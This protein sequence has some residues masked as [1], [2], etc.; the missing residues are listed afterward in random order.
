MGAV[1]VFYGGGPV[2]AI[3]VTQGG[4]TTNLPA[5]P[6]A[7]TVMTSS[8]MV[9][10][11]IVNPLPT[12]VPTPA[13]TPAPTPTVAPT[14]VPSP[15]PSAAPSP[16]PQPSSSAD[17]G[18][19]SSLKKIVPTSGAYP[20]YPSSP[21]HSVLPASPQVVPAATAAAW[22]AE[23]SPSKFGSITIDPSGKNANDGGNPVT[24]T[25]GDGQNVNISCTAVS[26]AVYSCAQPDSMKNMNGATVAIP[27]PPI[28]SLIAEGTTDHHVGNIDTAMDGELSTWDA[29]PTPAAPGDTWVVGGAGICPLFGN[30][31]ACSGSTATNI[32][33][34]LGDVDPFALEVCLTSGDP[35]C[36]LP[37]AL[38]IAVRCDNGYEFPASAGDN[39]C[40]SPG[41]GSAVGQIHEGKRVFLN[42]S[43]ATDDLVNAT[44]ADPVS[45]IIMRTMDS[46]H[47]GAFIR[48]SAWSGGSGL[49]LQWLSAQAWTEF[50]MPDPWIPVA[51]A[52]GVNTSSGAF[53]IP[54][55]IPLTSWSVCTNAKADGLCD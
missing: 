37:T 19:F 15:S 29:Y 52:V 43:L 5:G 17:V 32:P 50:G 18:P 39:Q 1:N 16:T 4:Q 24:Y 26:W 33:L 54:I 42:G 13:P 20:W 34:S 31:F 25:D 10:E 55:N 12:P 21:Y 14:P 22:F 46:Q 48:D 30:G 8:P 47:Y 53:V 51:Q 49:Q 11:F 44:S 41:P 35:H 2:Y 28:G 9:V 45:K 38:S 36:V 40:F 27:F 23:Q 3:T 7:Y 6:T